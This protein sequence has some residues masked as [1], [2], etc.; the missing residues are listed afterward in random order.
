MDKNQENNQ[1]EE[2]SVSNRD[3][4]AWLTFIASNPSL[5]SEGVKII[6]D[7]TDV[8]NQGK[9][10]VEKFKKTGNK[11]I[12]FNLIKSKD[13]SQEEKASVSHSNDNNV[14]IYSDMGDNCSFSIYVNSKNYKK[15]EKLD[16]PEEILDNGKKYKIGNEEFK[17][18]EG[19]ITKDYRAEMVN[20][21]YLGNKLF[22]NRVSVSVVEENK[23]LFLQFNMTL[24]NHKTKEQ[25]ILVNEKQSIQD[26]GFIIN[27]N[28]LPKELTHYVSVDENANLVL[29]FNIK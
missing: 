4:L 28:G 21:R 7:G 16:L 26:V 8:I 24:F 20:T 12:L 9:L 29:E 2:Q 13:N 27:E 3:K 14:V 18:V 15:F 22:V 25:Y 6:Q 5:I 19:V 10:L 17:I 11:S 23:K 1:T